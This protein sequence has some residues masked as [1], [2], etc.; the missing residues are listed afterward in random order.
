MLSLLWL[1]PWYGWEI[2]IPVEG[3]LEIPEQNMAAALH[4]P[5]ESLAATVSEQ[6]LL[7]SMESLDT[8]KA[9][10]KILRQAL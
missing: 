1:E 7:S 5:Q 8:L 6:G 10:Q 9:V 2:G 3:H 4:P